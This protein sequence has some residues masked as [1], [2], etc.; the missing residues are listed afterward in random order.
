M[1]GPDDERAQAIAQAVRDALVDRTLSEHTAQ[2]QQINGSQREM[3]KSLAEM[4]V[5][6][7]AV[8]KYVKD[9][10]AGQ[11]SKWTLWLGVIAAVATWVAIIATLISTIF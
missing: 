7:E 10:T 1:A 3:A 2:L 9:Q 8:A 4:T 6:S 11:F 5:S